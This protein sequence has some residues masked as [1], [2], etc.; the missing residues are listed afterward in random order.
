ML[1]VDITARFTQLVQGPEEHLPL[2]EAALLIAAH[3]E[4]GLDVADELR[5]L[6]QLAVGCPSPTLEAWWHRLFVELG[7]VGN[8]THYD[9]PRNSFLNFV[10]RRRTGIPITLGVVG[11]EVGRRLGLTLVGIGMPGH[12]LLRHEGSPPVFIDAFHGGVLLDDIGCQKR[13]Y[14]IYGPEVAFDVSYLAPV[15]PRI[16]LGRML[17]N[18]RRIY[19]AQRDAAGVAWVLRLRQ[20]IPG[21][22]P[23]ERAELGRVLA[24]AGRFTEAAEEL[25][26]LAADLPDQAETFGR[27]ALALRAKLN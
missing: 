1:Q 2:D 6:D 12:F 26:I 11:M 15:G 8:T 23:E 14:E 18:L 10:V 4:P 25:E 27:E 19:G 9:D 16:I 24:S 5:A 21:T 3:A 22:P 20:A 13:F 7:F 17:N